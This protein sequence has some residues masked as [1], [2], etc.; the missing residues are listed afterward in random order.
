[1]RYIYPF[2]LI[3]S[4]L[5]VS[6]EE[7]A[8]FLSQEKQ[9]ILRLQ[10]DI[11]E[12]EYEKLRTDWISPLN[13]TG[14][15]SYDKSVQEDFRSTTERI[16]ASISQDIFRSGGITYQIAY[17][18]AKKGREELSWFQ[19][20]AGLNRQ[21]F[22]ALLNYRKTL[23]QKEQTLLKLKN[24]EIEIFIKRQLYDV[25][26]ADIT[27]LNNALMGQSSELKTLAS[28]DYTI[29]EQRYEIARLSD[30]VPETF[31]LPEF[32]LVQKEE[33]MERQFDLLY[34]R[35]NT[36]VLHRLYGVT[37]T[38]YLPRVALDASAGYQNYDP[39][40]RSGGYDGNYYRAGIS[41]NLPLTYN[42]SSAIQE[43]KATYLKEAAT[44]A[45]RQRQIRADYAQSIDKIK[46]YQNAITITLRNLELYADLIGAV[47][48]G[49]DA[50]TKTGYD[51]Q[52]LH[53]TKII[54]EY[55]I[56]I[57]EINTQIELVKLHF[58]LNTSKDVR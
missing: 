51:L 13:L 17:A 31:V 56:K 48:A 11:Y 39:L 21:L 33:Y 26:K 50:G 4:V 54:E 28:L 41:V 23:Y 52:T 38:G 37:T 20:I 19:E 32:E 55:E 40:G 9:E 6:A 35:A 45:D 10:Q 16:S 44:A 27:E 18:D 8:S 30:I 29:A 36:E 43:A 47:R 25:G 53:N 42:A 22:T 15:F 7:T 2:C 14:S 46:S 24:K 3:L 5:P 57:N 49:V 12:S 34:A 58:A 1:M